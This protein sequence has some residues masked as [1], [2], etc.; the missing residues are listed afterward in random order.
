[1]STLFECKNLTKNYGQPNHAL[2]QVNLALEEGRIVGLLGP[3][4][5][6]K[7]T[8]LKMANGLIRPTGGEILLDG[9]APG[10][11]TKEFVSYLPD[12]EYLP[13]WMNV[14]GLLDMYEDFFRILTGI[15]R[16][17]C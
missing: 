1:M 6:G 13:D 9:L 7:T 3:N 12:A 10:A 4:G 8:M 14:R 5:S 2:D 17:I 16:R 15:K 11:E